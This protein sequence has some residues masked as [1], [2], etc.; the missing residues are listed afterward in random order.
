MLGGRVDPLWYI[1]TEDRH[2]SV[3][4]NMFQVPGVLKRV[5]G[6]WIVQ[7]FPSDD[8]LPDWE[9]EGVLVTGLRYEKPREPGAY[10]CKP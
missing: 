7:L 9:N 5:E 2:I 3:R 4:L 8:S 6:N 1:E 10:T